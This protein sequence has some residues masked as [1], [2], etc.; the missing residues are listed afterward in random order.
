VIFSL[1]NPIDRG[2]SHWLMMRS[3]NQLKEKDTFELTL[4]MVV[5]GDFNLAPIVSRFH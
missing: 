1:R 2:Y 4:A 5:V 3:W